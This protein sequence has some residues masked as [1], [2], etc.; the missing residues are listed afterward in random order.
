MRDRCDVH[1]HGWKIPARCKLKNQK[2]VDKTNLWSQS[3]KSNF[4]PLPWFVLLIH[5]QLAKWETYIVQISFVFLFLKQNLALFLQD[6]N[7]F[8]AISTSKLISNLLLYFKILKI[9]RC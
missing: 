4:L 3:A 1:K 8:Q 6:L 2:E 7:Q 9:F 5:S